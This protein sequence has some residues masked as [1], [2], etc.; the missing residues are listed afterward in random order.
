MEGGDAV[1]LPEV[2]V[3][4]FAGEDEV[5]SVVLRDATLNE[6]QGLGGYNPRFVSGEEYPGILSLPPDEPP[7][8]AFLGSSQYALTGKFYFDFEEE[9]WH[10]QLWLWN[11][12]DGSLVYTDKLVAVDS[13]ESL[14]YLSAMVSWIFSR[15]PKEETEEPDSR[16]EVPDSAAD[17]AGA[18]DPRYEVENDIQTDDPQVKNDPLDNWL[19]LGLRAGGSFRFYTLPELTKDYY[20]NSPLDFT[21]EASFQVAF[22]FLPFMSVQA[23]AVFTQDSAKFQGPEYHQSASGE[24]WHIFYTDRYSSMSLLFPVTIKF[25]LVFDPYII[26]PFGGV[27]MALPL[28]KMRLDSNIA[29]RKIGEFDYDLNGYFGLTAGV[30]LGIRVGPGILFLDARYSSDLGETIVRIDDGSIVSYRRAMLSF[31]LGY[32]LALLNKKRRVGGK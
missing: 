13:D 1:P 30:D 24:S 23:E 8:P 20:F 11:S 12:G 22:K 19:Y 18:P 2:A 21:Y 3:M 26:S 29:T 7:G 17:T 31:S 10:F 14:S 15:I 25:P 9:M 4:P 16:L 27:Y 5:L 6:V 28:G 32:E